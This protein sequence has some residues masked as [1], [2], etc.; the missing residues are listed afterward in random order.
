MVLKGYNFNS[1]CGE[2]IITNMGI[3]YLVAPNIKDYI[4]R[5]S[6][7]SQDK[8][9]LNKIRKLLFDQV[10]SCRCRRRVCGT[11]KKY[12]HNGLSLCKLSSRP[13]QP[14]GA[15]TSVAGTYFVGTY[16]PV[17][18]AAGRLDQ[19]WPSRAPR[20]RPHGGTPDTA[21]GNL[22]DFG[23]SFAGRE[24]RSQPL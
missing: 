13:A 23:I 24:E 10:L 6:L 16:R 9:K 14:A 1:R 19:P 15:D 18:A 11:S 5:A 22:S 12:C 17:S 7:L 20:A 8:K 4:K 3:N 2:S 21:F